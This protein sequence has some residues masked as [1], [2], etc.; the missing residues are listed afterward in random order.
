MTEE[1]IF[2]ERPRSY[3][4]LLWN[5]IG[6]MAGVFVVFAA[7]SAFMAIIDGMFLYHVYIEPVQ[8]VS[9]AE[10][11]TGSTVSE[12]IDIYAASFVIYLTLFVVCTTCYLRNKE[13]I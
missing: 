3:L 7:I 2:R 4:F 5:W 12:S 11:N 13:F 1:E 10:S 6:G 9:A 8:A